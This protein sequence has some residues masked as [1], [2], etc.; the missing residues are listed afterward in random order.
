M[1]KLED[2]EAHL[3]RFMLANYS[4]IESQETPELKI[5]AIIAMLRHYFLNIYNDVAQA[6]FELVEPKKS[7]E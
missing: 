6:E 7:Q 5:D 4:K 3:K 1:E 2:K